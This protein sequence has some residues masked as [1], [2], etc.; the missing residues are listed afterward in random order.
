VRYAAA[1]VGRYLMIW[2]RA[3]SFFTSI[4]SEKQI[5]K[6]TMVATR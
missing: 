1:G 2:M 4:D 6:Y 3:C 5:A